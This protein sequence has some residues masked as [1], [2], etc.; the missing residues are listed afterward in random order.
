[1][2]LFQHPLPSYGFRV[3]ALATMLACGVHS[4]SWADG[5]TPATIDGAVGAADVLVR[6][7]NIKQLAGELQISLCTRTEFEVEDCQ[8]YIGAPVTAKSMTVRFANAPA[9]DWAVMLI[10]DL[11][12]NDKMDYNFLG[13][14]KE[15]FGMSNLRSFPLRSPR[16]SDVDFKTKGQPVAITVRLFN[17]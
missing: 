2:R 16:F 5:S 15:P 12:G 6:I 9:G 7:D 3:T 17:Q 10:Q 14:P 8:R 11:N 4:L 1:M 13:L